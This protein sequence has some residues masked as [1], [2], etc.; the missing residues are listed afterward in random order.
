MDQ[1]FSKFS[2]EDLEQMVLGQDGIY[3]FDLYNELYDRYVA[4][5][6]IDMAA[7]AMERLISSFVGE[8]DS[9]TLVNARYKQALIY[10]NAENF[11]FAATYAEKGTEDWEAKSATDSHFY[12]EWSKC[13]IVQ[14]RS[15]L[16][17]GFI[18]EIPERAERL[19]EILETF[20]FRNFIPLVHLIIA[21]AYFHLELD[22][23]CEE[24]L[25][26]AQAG[27]PFDSIN[28]KKID[29]LRNEM[30]AGTQPKFL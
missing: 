21:E 23:L 5:N 11:S 26:L 18:S 13:A 9:G 22:D 16:A 25:K 2:I 1:D 3:K 7:F 30:S 4:K 6:D 14:L 28:Q 19:L 20:K 17:L 24:Y 29:F 15:R 10:F 8:I 12:L 27:T